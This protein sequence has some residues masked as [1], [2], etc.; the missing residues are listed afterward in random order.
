MLSTKLIGHENTYNLIL[1]NFINKSISNS[2]IFYGN[3]G[4][5][6]ATFTYHLI[7]TLFK[8]LDKNS[9][10]DNNKLIYN[11]SHPNIKVI[12][13]IYDEKLKKYKTNI[14]IDQIR[15]IE[16]FVYQS[17]FSNLPKFILIDSADELNNNSANSLLKILEE[18]TKN[19]YFFLISH[20]ISLILPT[21]R[22]RCFKFNFLNPNKDIFTEILNNFDDGIEQS[23]LNLLYDLSNNSPGIAIDLYNQNITE[24]FDFILFFFKQNESLSYELYEFSDKV[25][26]FDNYE[27]KIYL[28]LIK[29]IIN[30][31]IKI[32]LGI[33][34]NHLHNSY[35]IKSLH[36]I[37][38]FL[39]NKQLFNILEYLNYN[40]NSL[41]SLNLDKKIFN[42]NIY[43]SLRKI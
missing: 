4:V 38:N 14:S 15:N 36:E 24:I 39:D 13:K 40:E 35:I 22:S 42:L 37:S 43:S 23:E 1:N 16:K 19:T 27:F 28:S 17:S 8:K 26:K 11:D 41:Y 34:L 32:N 18:P 21:I 9:G 29:F 30:N 25:N 2:I 12:R 31:V 5:G 20:Q 7:S 3:K 33:N 10:N 6:K